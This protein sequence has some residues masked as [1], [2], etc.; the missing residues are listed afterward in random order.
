MVQAPGTIEPIP[1]H[2][3]P[4]GSGAVWARRAATALLAA[5]VAAG[6]ANVFGQRSTT[7][8]A[9]APAARLTVDGPVRLRQGDVGQVR[10]AVAAATR[11]VRPRLVLGDGFLEQFTVNTITPEPA[12][13]GAGVGHWLLVYDPVP[14]GGTLVVRIQFQ[15]G[16]QG[17]GKRSQDVELRDGDAVLASVHRRLIVFP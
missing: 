16:S 6:L 8:V 7:T 9:E 12:A 17:A 5:F 10:I 3:A 4:R 14:A 15:V 13:E 1:G 2:S 11:I